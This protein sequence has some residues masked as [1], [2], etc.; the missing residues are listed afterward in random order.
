MR[1]VLDWKFF[2]RV[3][4]AVTALTLFLSA[5]LAADGAETVRVYDETRRAEVKLREAQL[6]FLRGFIRDHSS[7]LDEYIKGEKKIETTIKIG[8]TEYSFSIHLTDLIAVSPGTSLE[9]FMKLIDKAIDTLR[10]DNR[11]HLT[12]SESKVTVPEPASVREIPAEGTPEGT[13]HDASLIQSL[14]GCIKDIKAEYNE[15][16]KMLTATIALLKAE[17][18]KTKKESE[19]KI[20]E[21]M[22]YM[23]FKEQLNQV[24]E[25]ASQFSQFVSKYAQFKRAQQMGDVQRAYQ[26]N[27]EVQVAIAD[28]FPKVEQQKRDFSYQTYSLQ[29]QLVQ[30]N[31]EFNKKETTKERKEAIQKEAAPLQQQ[32]TM[33]F[34]NSQQNEM[35]GQKL[36]EILQEAQFTQSTREQNLMSVSAEQAEALRQIVG[37][38]QFQGQGVVRA[39][40]P[41]GQQGPRNQ[42]FAGFLRTRANPYVSGAQIQAREPVATTLPSDGFI[43]SP[44]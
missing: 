18:D 33:A 36:R 5:A 15:S 21:L 20:T 25:V 11:D 38:G 13:S 26:L 34:R 24:N 10:A 43:S 28:I 8:T 30:L 27:E 9:D 6:A 39:V 32:L 3:A 22:H 4:V 19:S 44:F 2:L 31:E 35:M 23:G 37:G 1:K 12:A 16:I 41:V 29:A 42:T 14:I 7:D 40:Q 17:L